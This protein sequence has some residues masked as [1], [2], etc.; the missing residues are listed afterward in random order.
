MKKVFYY[1]K[2]ISIFFG[3]IL[4][5]S[6]TTSLLNLAGLNKNITSIILFILQIL[7]FFIIGFIHGK[8]TNKKAF[9]E[10]LIISIILVF[11]MLILSLILFKYIFKFSNLIYYIILIVA[12][13]SGAILGKNK[14]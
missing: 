13:T 4:F 8:K 1:F 3:I 12:S 9:V 7:L 5:F 14:K 6:A 11:I 10:G 2:K